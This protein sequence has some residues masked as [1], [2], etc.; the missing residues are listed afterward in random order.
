ML[1]GGF[2]WALAD[3]VCAM[4]SRNLRLRFLI[5]ISS[6]LG[7]RIR[8]WCLVMGV[9]DRWGIRRSLLMS[10]SRRLVSVLIVVFLS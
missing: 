5:Y 4:G 9:E 6:R 2:E 3:W 8:G 1:G 10:I 7:G